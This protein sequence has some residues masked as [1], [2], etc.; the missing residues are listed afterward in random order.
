MPAL[1][2]GCGGGGSEPTAVEPMTVMDAQTS[3]VSGT[4]SLTVLSFG[5]RCF[6]G[7]SADVDGFN[8]ATVRVVQ[9][10]EEITVSAGTLVF[11]GSVTGRQFEV[12]EQ[13]TDNGANVHI[14]LAGEFDAEGWQGEYYVATNPDDVTIACAGQSVFFGDRAF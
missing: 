4:Y 1:L 14:L 10:G 8:N 9:I 12:A 2:V 5:I 11:N 13:Y 6:D 7:S 3:D